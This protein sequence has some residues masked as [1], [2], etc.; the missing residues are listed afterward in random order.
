[1]LSAQRDFQASLPE[2]QAEEVAQQC[3]LSQTPD[4]GFI[5]RVY[6]AP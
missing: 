6:G 1:M 3:N 5:M 2:G 4:S